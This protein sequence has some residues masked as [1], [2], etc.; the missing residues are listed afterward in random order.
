MLELVIL[1]QHF[2]TGLYVS[3]IGIARSSLHSHASP[4]QKV[5]HVDTYDDAV[6]MERLG[7]VRM[8]E[9]ILQTDALKFKHVVVHDIARRSLATV[10]RQFTEESYISCR[11]PSTAENTLID[12]LV[13][14]V[15]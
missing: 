2:H 4:M 14:D 8:V 3:R 9:L 5:A 13:H 11:I 7:E 6:Q 10:I 12:I 1:E 15:V